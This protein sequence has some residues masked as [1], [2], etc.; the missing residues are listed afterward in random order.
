M[1][2]PKPIREAEAILRRKR[3]PACLALA[4][5]ARRAYQQKT[6]VSF[7][8]GPG[9]TC[10]TKWGGWYR[11]K[12]P[13]K[14]RIAA[15]HKAWLNIEREYRREEVSRLDKLYPIIVPLKEPRTPL[16]SLASAWHFH[17]W[18]STRNIFLD[19]LEEARSSGQFRNPYSYIEVKLTERGRELRRKEV[20]ERHDFDQLA[21][22]ILAGY[23]EAEARRKIAS[24][25]L[26][27]EPT[28]EKEGEI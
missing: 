17:S 11:G 9:I 13:M 2:E 15:Y 28:P 25:N 14:R 19:N 24:G 8:G 23:P 26:R 12:D 22:L 3:Q 6:P 20:Q 4:N 27:I 18:N 21:N 16:Q 1:N 10:P 7:H 5:Q